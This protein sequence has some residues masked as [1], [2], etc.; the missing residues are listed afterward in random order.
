MATPHRLRHHPGALS[1]VKWHALKDRLLSDVG[2]N[3][4]H[5]EHDHSQQA[6][7]PL[8]VTHTYRSAGIGSGREPCG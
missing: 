6:H 1:V 3:R 8:K 7:V 5:R 2:Q 4:P